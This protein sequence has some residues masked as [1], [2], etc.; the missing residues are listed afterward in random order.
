MD[1]RR[2][3]AN[4]LEGDAPMFR[5]DDL[6]E[7]LSHRGL[8]FAVVGGLLGFGITTLSARSGST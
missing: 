4:P 8:W 3:P 7:L 5:R 2:R 1:G 6:L